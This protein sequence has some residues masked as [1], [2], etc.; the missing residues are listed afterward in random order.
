MAHP[1][2]RHYRRSDDFCACAWGNSL[3]G[4]SFESRRKEVEGSY[5][6]E[7][8]A[9]QLVD[10]GGAHEIFIVPASRQNY[11]GAR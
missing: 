4:I 2:N 11:L 5:L 9:K 8:N 3:P 10:V 7:V 1:S 6:I